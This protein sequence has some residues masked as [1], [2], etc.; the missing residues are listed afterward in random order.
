MSHALNSDAKFEE[1]LNLS[2][3]NDMNN[4]VNFKGTRAT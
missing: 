1:K 4:S 3:R 2:S